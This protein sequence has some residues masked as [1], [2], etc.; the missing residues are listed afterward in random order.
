M[1][2]DRGD[3]RK[4]APETRHDILGIPVS[5]TVPIRVHSAANETRPIRH[6]K[7]QAKAFDKARER[8]VFENTVP[9][10]LVTTN[11]Q[12]GIAPPGHTLTIGSAKQSGRNMVDS[13]NR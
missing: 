13:H 10:C 8:H 4:C 11:S 7:A 1:E 6:S 3:K 9:N 2:D 5:N 12:I